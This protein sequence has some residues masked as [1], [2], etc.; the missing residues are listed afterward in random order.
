MWYV[1]WREF[2]SVVLTKGFIIGILL[3]PALI[4]VAAG[5]AALAS[6]LGAPRIEGRVAVVDQSGAV[7]VLIEKAF[8][9]EGVKSEA[10]GDQARINKV[11]DE[12]VT[13]K[14]PP[15]TAAMAKQ[16]ISSGV[17]QAKQPVQIDVE[18]VPAGADIEKLK[19]VVRSAD[20]HADRGPGGAKPLL[21]VVVI[22]AASVT[23]AA[24][25]GYA[26]FEVF[27][28]PK[29]DFQV[30][31]QIERRVGGAIVDARLATD[32][33]VKA[34]RLTP[35]SLRKM[36]A[37]PDAK[38]VTLTSEGQR[39][40]VGGL[41][42]L[43]PLGFMLLLMISVMTAGQYLMTALIE[44]KSSRVMEVLLSA[45]SPM[46]LM[47]G[48]ILGQMTVALLIMVVY[49]GL[50]ISGLVVFA[51]MDLIEPIK[52]VWFVCFFFI[53]FFTVA[54]MMAAIGAAVNEMRE[55]QTLLTPVMMVVMLPWFLWLPIQRAPNSTFAT[56]LSFVP[57]VN[58]FVMVLRLGGSEPVPLWQVPLSLAVGLA[59][60][61]FMA[62]AAAKIF[63]IG[64]LM[65]GKP[66]NLATLI[67][68][69]R[70]A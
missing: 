1:A 12:Q 61:V 27:L 20:I 24:D 42:M 34:S 31:Q 50:G 68:W 65:Y 10:E 60:V 32:E 63:R 51:L 19:A 52:L 49:G 23:P 47:V 7:G 48:K 22:S 29:L 5:G 21:G 37:R 39:E 67:K 17:Q 36:L 9:P 40:S 55:A 25:G 64:V 14:F 43:L 26:T 44:E 4:A 35:D 30:Q 59:S 18:L 33:R 53:A 11:I 28:P 13:A 15:D 3:T 41:Q 38:S 70:M 54:S 57:L 45:V 56:V 8:S 69:V 46:Q 2:T 16:Q 58:P 6:R 62:W 66:P